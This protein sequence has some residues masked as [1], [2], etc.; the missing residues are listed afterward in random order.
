[1]SV[2]SNST[3]FNISNKSNKFLEIT[4]SADQHC[5]F[6]IHHSSPNIIEMQHNPVKHSYLSW[7]VE[8][9][10][11]WSRGNSMQRVKINLPPKHTIQCDIYCSSSLEFISKIKDKKVTDTEDGNMSIHPENQGG[12]LHL[13]YS[14]T[15]GIPYSENGNV[16]IHINQAVY[17]SM[18]ITSMIK[19]MDN[20]TVNIAQNT[21]ATCKLKI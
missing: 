11:G 4:V 15:M 17:R 9:L 7:A 1:M 10:T 13:I 8:K 3:H 20:Y 12:E 19:T 21:P 14:E 18:V 6:R 5:T 2:L 16:A